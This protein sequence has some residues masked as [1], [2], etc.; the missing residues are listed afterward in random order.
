MSLKKWKIAVLSALLIGS[1]SFLQAAEPASSQTGCLGDSSCPAPQS[2]T[3]EPE[4]FNAPK[5]FYK[6]VDWSHTGLS[7]KVGELAERIDLFIG[8]LRTCEDSSGSN[9]Q[10]GG[11]TAVL[12]NGALR[13]DY[14]LNAK[15]ELPNTQDRFRLVIESRPQNDLREPLSPG[16]R[17]STE[18]TDVSPQVAEASQLSTFLQFMTQEKGKWDIKADGGVEVD[19]PPDPF[20]RLRFQRALSFGSWRLTG[21][22]TLF[23]Y[24]SLGLGEST[25]INLDIH[26]ESCMLFRAAAQVVWKERMQRFD[27]SQT[28]SL[29]QELSWKEV[30]TYKVGVTGDTEPDLHMKDWGIGVE[31]RRRIYKNW[32]YIAIE[33]AVSFSSVNDFETNPS[34]RFTFDMTFGPRYVQ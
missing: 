21:E 14:I 17:S 22:E 16:T 31:Y 5:T 8:G 11:S 10:V 2:Q 15:I 12:K 26:L 33:P 6:A 23:W 4:L 30:L 9:F 3:G 7:N 25:Q 18:S 13:F 19:F 32:L 1:A 34:I 27:L 29:F 20:T 28:F 24:Q